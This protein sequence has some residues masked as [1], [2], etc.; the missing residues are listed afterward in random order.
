MSDAGRMKSGLDLVSTIAVMA[1]AGAVLW[2]VFVRQPAAVAT[3]QVEPV[4][5][6]RVKPGLSSNMSGTGRIA[7][8]EFFDFQCPF[9]RQHAR[10]TLPAIM[11]DFVESG[12]ARYV[13]MHYPIEEIHPLALGASEAAE[14]AAKQGRF[15]E[16]RERL[17]N[18]P[19]SLT[20]TQLARQ[21][22]ALRLNQTLFD[23]CLTGRATLEKVRADRAEGR[24]LGVT[25]TPA[26]FLGKVSSD[27]GIDLAVRIRGVATAEMFTAQITKLESSA[28]QQASHQTW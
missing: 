17:F 5:G 21:A 8:V 25:G 24:R 2:H 19:D 11:R 18:E 13:A 10:N 16:M 7:I 15:W 28:G 26:F 23:E 12:R 4:K 20:A 27:G 3:Q 9:C 14:C 1:A 22:Q 6:L